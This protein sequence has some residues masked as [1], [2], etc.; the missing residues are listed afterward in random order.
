[1]LKN[2]KYRNELE[3]LL[4][5][6]F[7][8]NGYKITKSIE[9]D[10]VPESAK[11]D[12]LFFALNNQKIVYRNGK[13]TPDRPGAFL[14]VWQRPSSSTMNS[15]KP[16]PLNSNELDYLFVKVQEHSNVTSDEELIKNSKYGLFI[17]PVSLLIEKNIVSSIK[18]RGKTGFRVFPPWSQDRGSVRT[19]V[20][21]ESGKKT[22]R[23]QIPYFLEVSN[24][25]LIDS[26]EL[27]K[28]FRHKFN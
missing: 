5:K 20:F 9:L 11:Y 7:I 4:I 25:N 21:S 1:M 28:I 16:I 8:P 24:D 14:T 18:N 22:Q 12:A 13:V 23:W 27:N 26:C 3:S 17:F 19:N 2:K 10:V 15:N 6:N